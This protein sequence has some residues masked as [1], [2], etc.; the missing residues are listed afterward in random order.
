MTKNII[1]Q[2]RHV[3]ER[4]DSSIESVRFELERIVDELND[5]IEKIEEIECEIEKDST[6][7]ISFSNYKNDSIHTLKEYQNIIL[8]IM[9][10]TL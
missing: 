4:M 3:K 9:E 5:S 7:Q 2:Y 1:T 8:Q 10:K 6:E